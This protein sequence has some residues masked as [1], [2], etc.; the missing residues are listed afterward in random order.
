MPGEGPY[1]TSSIKPSY[2][3][4]MMQLRKKRANPY[5]VPFAVAAALVLG[6]TVGFVLFGD[7]ETKIVRQIVEVPAK[8]RDAIDEKKAA[9]EIAEEEGEAGEEAEVGSA[10]SGSK[11]SGSGKTASASG[12]E[13]ADVK[14]LQGLSG[15]EGLD[16]PSGGPAGP[17]GSNAGTQELSSSQIP[18]TVSKYPNSV[19]R[20][21]WERALMTRDKKAP[22]SARVWVAI[23]VAPGGHVTSATARGDPNG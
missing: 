23:K 9:Q 21:C 17:S 6:V 2:D 10:P 15:L 7:Q 22:S 5:V 18:S 12:S 19:K 16:G 14:G 11:A 20:G 4:L 8:V 13:P 3:S 1:V